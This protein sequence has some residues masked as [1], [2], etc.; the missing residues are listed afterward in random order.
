MGWGA[1]LD[2]ALVCT[3]AED[4]DRLPEP[5]LP[6]GY[7]IREMDMGDAADVATWLS[8]HNE[9]FGRS[10]G[11]PEFEGAIL[12]HPHFDVQRTFFVEDGDRA[13]GEASIGV[14]RRNRAVGVG[15]YLAV[16]PAAQGLGLGRELVVHRYRALRDGGIR[17][18]E[19]HTHIG[20]VRSLRIHF[21]CGFVPKLRFDEWNTPNTA[22]APVRVL[23]N[24]RLRSLHRRW[25]REQRTAPA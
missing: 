13:L 14:F 15:H 10:W 7:R 22:T 25:L 1:T 8:V 24:A 3:R 11:A 18:C 21:E 4:L 16:S 2:R 23:T 20:R 12:G 19:S 6:A 9:A 17:Q 5:R